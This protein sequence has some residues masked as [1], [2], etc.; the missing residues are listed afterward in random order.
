MKTVYY[1]DPNNFRGIID[2]FENIA[3]DAIAAAAG[4]VAGLIASPSGPGAVG[5]AVAAAAAAK[6][7][8]SALFNS[9]GTEGFKRHMLTEEDEGAT[10]EIVIRGDNTVEFRSKSGNS[11]TVTSTKSV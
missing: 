1:S 11:E 8:T 3:P 4:A 7:T 10:T 5:A 9:E 2:G 6:A